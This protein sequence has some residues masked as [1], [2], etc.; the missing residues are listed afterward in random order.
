MDA[1]P[2]RP[3]PGRLLDESESLTTPGNQAGGPD[4]AAQP[5][6]SKYPAVTLTTLLHHVVFLGRFTAPIFVAAILLASVVLADWLPPVAPRQSVTQPTIENGVGVQVVPDDPTPTA[7]QTAAPTA[8]PGPTVTHRPATTTATAPSAVIA[9]TPNTTPT[10]LQ[11]T[12]TLVLRECQLTNII[13]RPD[14]WYLVYA[15]VNLIGRCTGVPVA[16]DYDVWYLVRRE[17]EDRLYR[18]GPIPFS[19]ATGIFDGPAFLMPDRLAA[20]K[21]RIRLV[22]ALLRRTDSEKWAL[23]YGALPHDANP[24]FLPPRPIDDLRREGAMII[25]T[26]GLEIAPE[27]TPTPTSTPTATVSLPPNDERGYLGPN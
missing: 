12:A 25:N 19:E 23:Q 21:E 16:S 14:G 20:P 4:Q 27:P 26:I 22:F 17:R 5:R 11:P 13:A 7:T 18:I 15:N 24:R 2:E 8:T 1:T 6:S 3:N 10:P 9:P